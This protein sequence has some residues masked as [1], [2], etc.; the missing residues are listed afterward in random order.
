MA[1]LNLTPDSF[2][3]GGAYP[4]VQA[5]VEAASR[6]AAEGADIL[7][8][9]GESTRPG[10]ARVPAD[11]QIRRVIP[12][13]T[14]IRAGRLAAIPISIDTTLS[15]VAAAAIEAGATIINDV[16]AGTEDP[17]ILNLAAMHRT[18]LV[19]MP[20]RA[21]PGKDS[22][23]DRYAEPPRYVDVVHAVREFL[24]SRAALAESR[25]VA[26]SSIILDPG[27]GFGKTVEQNLELIRRTPELAMLGYPILSGVSRKSFVGRAARME[28]S[29]PAERLAPSIALTVAHY[30]A[31][32]SIF[33]VHDVAP[34]V[35]ALRAA[36]T[37]CQK[38]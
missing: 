14:A 32:A 15:P 35:Q 20:R 3:D 24:A 17:A 27:L 34:A 26:R 4:T 12:V 9:G 7:D 29:M 22:Y 36:S 37:A 11:E 18:G 1:I 38:P 33:R 6:A 5:A 28:T 31:G 19:L 2:S 13:L 8:L 16:S 23:S 21:P 25:G 30:F 10:A